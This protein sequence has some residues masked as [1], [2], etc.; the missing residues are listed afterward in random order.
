MKFALDE[1]AVKEVM[2]LSLDARSQYLV[3]GSVNVDQQ[4]IDLIWADGLKKTVP[5]NRF[6]TSGD[7][8]EPNYADVSIIDHGFTLKLGEYE[9]DSDSL[10]D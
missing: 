3:E 6:K 2:E 1:S 8:I 5:F 4:T 10:R 9:A 7:G